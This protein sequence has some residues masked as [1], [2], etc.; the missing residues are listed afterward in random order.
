MK[1][2]SLL[3]WLPSICFWENIRIVTTVSTVQHHVILKCSLEDQK[4]IVYN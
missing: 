1:L 3:V 4:G 2:E